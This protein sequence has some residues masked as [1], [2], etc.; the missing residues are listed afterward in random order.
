[1]KMYATQKRNTTIFWRSAMQDVYEI[2]QQ[3]QAE[4]ARVRKEI[5]CLNIAAPLLSDD[6]TSNDP[7]PNSAEPANPLTDTISRLADSAATNVDNLF[8]SV[9]TR[10]SLWKALKR[11][12]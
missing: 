12:R 9:A 2:L 1:M 10:S 4:L 7:A 6:R 8:S 3:K 11:A 5:E